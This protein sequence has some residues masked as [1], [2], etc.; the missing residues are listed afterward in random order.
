MNYE[1]Y[2]KFIEENANKEESEAL[3]VVNEILRHHIDGN[4]AEYSREQVEFYP[5][6]VFNGEKERIEM[7]LLMI[8]KHE[9]ERYNRKIGIEFKEYDSQKVLSQAITRRKYVDYM[10]VATRNIAF[11]Y[12]EVFLM[13]YFGIG[14]VIWENGFAKMIF[15]A[16]YTTTDYIFEEIINLAI[17]LKLGEKQK[18]IEEK[19]SSIMEKASTLDRFI[20]EDSIRKGGDESIIYKYF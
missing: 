3:E 5:R 8:L 14:W 18:E 4:W 10:Y 12:K 1:E 7:D 17:E 11:S 15:P 19:V 13:P 16:R 9:K 20:R 6:F 2:K